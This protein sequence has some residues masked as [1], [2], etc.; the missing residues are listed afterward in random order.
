[1]SQLNTFSNSEQQMSIRHYSGVK[2][3]FPFS[4][5]SKFVLSV[6]AGGTFLCLSLFLGYMT[7]KEPVKK[8]VD[9]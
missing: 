8:M 7:S 2:D 5:S 1:M 4:A 9:H 3:C 6:M